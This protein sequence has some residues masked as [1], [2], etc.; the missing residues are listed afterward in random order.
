MRN[1]LLKLIVMSLLF[2]VEVNLSLMFGK[3]NDEMILVKHLQDREVILFKKLNHDCNVLL[4]H[5]SNVF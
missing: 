1:L 3:D 2:W 5:L 4:F